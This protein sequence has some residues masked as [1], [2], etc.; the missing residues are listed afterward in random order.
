MATKFLLAALL[1]APSILGAAIPQANSAV[2]FVERDVQAVGVDSL[3]F[4]HR[5]EANCVPQ[6]DYSIYGRDVVEDVEEDVSATPR[7]G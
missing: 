2:S 6:V 3:H 4:C 5:S 1:F 7:L